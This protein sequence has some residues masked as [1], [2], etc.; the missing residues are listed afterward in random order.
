[1]VFQQFEP[2]QYRESAQAS[3]CIWSNMDAILEE[4]W[5]EA[6]QNLMDELPPITYLDDLD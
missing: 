2:N 4:S 6:L 5:Q 1:M 3:D